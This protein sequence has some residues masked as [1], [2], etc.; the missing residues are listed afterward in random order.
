[1]FLPVKNINVNNALDK[2]D[3][4]SNPYL[5][6]PVKGLRK[7]APICGHRAIRSCRSR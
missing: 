3:R 4:G 5:P 7:P 2:E 6:L 1:M